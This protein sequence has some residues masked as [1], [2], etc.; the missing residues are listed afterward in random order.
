M[1]PKYP[2]IK[3]KLVGEDGNIFFI[4]GRLSR[5]LESKKVPQEEIDEVINKIMTSQSYDEALQ[6]IMQTVNVS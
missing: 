2:N 1:K 6:I 5:K 4:M 3:F